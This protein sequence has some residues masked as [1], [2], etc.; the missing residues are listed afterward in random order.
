MSNYRYVNLPDEINLGNPAKNDFYRRAVVIQPGVP[1]TKPF[2][3]IPGTRVM[4][5]V[6][7]LNDAPNGNNGTRFLEFLLGQE[8]QD[9]LLANGPTPISPAVVS[10]RD[11]RKLP[12]SLQALVKK[13][14]VFSAEHTRG[15]EAHDEK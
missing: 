4:W 1:G 14:H 12:Q 15:S 10:H 7:A 9:A 5:G 8:G 3:P 2:V 11:Y 6:T 13:A